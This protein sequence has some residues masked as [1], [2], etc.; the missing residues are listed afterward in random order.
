MTIK[1]TF[2]LLALTLTPT[3]AMAACS[4]ESHAQAQSCA[5]GKVYDS[6]AM[7]CVPVTG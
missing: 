7:N 4:G 6:A 2:V 5:D 1:T 3:W